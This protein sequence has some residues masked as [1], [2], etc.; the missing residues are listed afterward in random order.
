VL[1]EAR[2]SSLRLGRCPFILH[3]APER[4]TKRA[5]DALGTGRLEH[6]AQVLPEYASKAFTKARELAAARTNLF[7]GLGEDE[8]PTLHEIRALSSHLYAKAG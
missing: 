2:L 5:E 7:A 4:R 3:R 1:H 6:S 8:M